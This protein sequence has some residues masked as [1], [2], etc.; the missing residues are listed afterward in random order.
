MKK[1][2]L[3][4][5]SSVFLIGKGIIIAALL[6]I[7]SLS[8]VLGYFVGKSTTKESPETKLSQANLQEKNVVVPQRSPDS[9]GSGESPVI[10]QKDT[11]EI[12]EQKTMVNEGK[13]GGTQQIGQPQTVQQN[14]E[15]QQTKKIN[16]PTHTL[17]KGGQEGF[18][19]ESS[20]NQGTKEITKTQETLKI[21]QT[22]KYT[23]QVGAFKDAHEADVLKAKLD[24]KGY[25]AY[26]TKTERK[27]LKGHKK[28]Y[29]VRIGEFETKKEADV[30]SVKIK[31]SERLQTFVT[32]Q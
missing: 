31:K 10:N 32:L 29:K 19:Q 15:S 9:S 14:A 16:P 11:A 4:E 26:I 22:P 2:E 27:G 3:K 5:G 18:A 25:T 24:K 17:S 23:V 20:K 21:S 6:I 30:L 13:E 12:A 8:F 1:T 28:I 7:S